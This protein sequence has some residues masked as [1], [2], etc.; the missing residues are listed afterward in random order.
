MSAAGPIYVSVDAEFTDGNFVHGSMLQ[1]GMVARLPDRSLRKFSAILPLQGPTLINPWVGENLW[2]LLARCR[3]VETTESAVARQAE[4]W[5]TSLRDAYPRSPSVGSD[6]RAPLVFVAWCGT[7]DWSYVMQ[8]L[9]RM[10]GAR[11]MEEI[12]L[13]H[14]EA[15]EISSLAM[16]AFGLGWNEVDRKTLGE[17]LGL[18]PQAEESMHD[19]CAD[20]EWQL[21]V[22]ERL[23][24]LISSRQ[25]TSAA[26]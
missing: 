17:R 23:M 13:F 6:G 20:A 5:L 15:I 18:A 2:P 7:A 4:L 8:M 3:R 1:L 22:F 9:Y 14:Y 21:E 25:A 24:A 12:N 26:G 16:G 10:R 19:A 11:P